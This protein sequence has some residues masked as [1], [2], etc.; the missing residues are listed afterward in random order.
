MIS[1]SAAG[2]I[3]GILFGV[4]AV[5]PL[6]CSAAA[7][8]FFVDPLRG[9]DA[10]S[11]RSVS[12]AFRTFHRA[13][14]AVSA[15]DRTG[16]GDLVVHL[17][18]GMYELDAPLVFL[19]E[20]SGTPRRKIIFKNFEDE[21][22][23]L[24]G[25]R[26]LRPE[27]SGHQGKI[28]KARIG[29]GLDFRQLYFDGQKGVRARTPNQG[30]YDRFESDIASDGFNVRSGLLSGITDLRGVEIA[31]RCKWM[32]KRMQITAV[33][34]EGSAERAVIDKEQWERLR[35]GPQ[36]TRKVKGERYWVENALE[37]LDHPGE[38]YYNRESGELYYWPADDGFNPPAEVVIPAVSTL[39]FLQGELD[40][41]V[42]HIRFEGL[43]FRHTGWTLPNRHGF[44]DV[45]AN[46]LLPV[47]GASDPQYR[48]K[49]KK[50]RVDAAVQVHSGQNIRI[51]NC[52]FEQLGGTGLTFNY[53]GTDNVIAGNRFTDI[54]ASAIE[55]GNDAWQ[56]ASAAMWP[57]RFVVYNN[58]IRRIGTEY[59]ASIAINVFYADSVLIRN[60]A[61]HDV[62]YTAI[63]TGW[64][65]SFEEVVLEARNLRIENN[66]IETYLTEMDD[67]AGIYSA[68]P[69]FGSVMS[70]NYIKDMK[71]TWPDPA[72]Y[73]DG[74]GAYWI[75]ESNVVE[76]ANR[77]LGQ[78]S[79]STQRKRD[80]TARDNF[81]TTPVISTYGVN[82]R[83]ENTQVY[84]N[85]D[86]PE[87]AL[88]IIA[89]AGR[90]DHP[91]P[92]LPV[93]SETVLLVDNTDPG[94]ST[95]SGGWETDM[96]IMD[97][98][99]GAAGP[100]YAYTGLGSLFE[101]KWAQWT[102][103]IMQEG[104]YHLYIRYPV[105][106][107]SPEYVPVEIAYA[108]GE[109]VFRDFTYDQRNPRYNNEWIF[110]GCFRLNAGTGNYIRLYAAGGGVTVAD[111]VK[112]VLLT[113]P[114]DE[115]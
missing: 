74:S 51:E 93:E 30:T 63:S 95:D 11:G 108:G 105:G 71:T 73:H 14:A 13:K 35:K 19:P 7:I 5:L 60:N 47:T 82:R 62:P 20:D 69:V 16:E 40:N 113:D 68:N 92:V 101:P 104:E 49:L 15:E 78:Q 111:A 12:D 26:V 55:I 31:A 91:V 75:V 89:Q 57:R 103:R 36:G 110:L 41:P 87:A 38:W 96:R 29:A 86:W 88:R 34:K 99:T 10:R 50:D 109:R 42:R 65:W 43:V 37:F 9:D 22:P 1:K 58:E 79:H 25:G 97:R 84:P 106:P 33:R 53:G 67:G 98:R 48:H 18:G 17:R 46:T 6:P 81:S 102:P 8:H 2:Q 39:V 115:K 4:L 114:S 44:L 66:R 28:L 64:G 56:P 100:D 21:V 80:I 59:F 90:S 77:W 32:H 3:I 107:A 85:A 27:W 61:I 72:I 45:Q 83:I 112:F 76:N 54:A 23:I 24:S 94:F 70:G 52:T